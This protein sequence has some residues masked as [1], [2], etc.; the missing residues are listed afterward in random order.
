MG[1]AEFGFLLLHHRWELGLFHRTPHAAA[2]K[3]RLWG[4]SVSV[5]Q[6]RPLDFL[7]RLGAD[8]GVAGE[9]L[10]LHGS[11]SS[12]PCDFPPPLCLSS[13]SRAPVGPPSPAS[14]PQEVTQSNV[15]PTEGE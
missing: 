9:E 10:C 11:L 4:T 3:V 15:S 13:P 5:L 8:S 7:S 2:R 14:L 12:S 1:Q 6:R